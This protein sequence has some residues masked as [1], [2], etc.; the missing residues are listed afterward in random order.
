MI[1]HRRAVHLRHHRDVEL[2]RAL[3]SQR[4]TDKPAAISRHEVDVRRRAHLRRN[5]E[6]ALVLAILRID[7]DEHLAVAR[8]FDDVFDLG[9]VIVKYRNGHLLTSRAT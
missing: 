9:N 6:I 5:N 3:L 7:K 1:S 2:L 4:K 8:V